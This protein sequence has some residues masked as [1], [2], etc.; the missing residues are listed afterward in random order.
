MLRVHSAGKLLG[1]G[2]GQDALESLCRDVGY[3]DVGWILGGVVI[4]LIIGGIV[5]DKLW[6]PILLPLTQ[7][8]PEFQRDA[9]ESY[10]RDQGFYSTTVVGVA[11]VGG[12]IIGLLGVRAW[13]TPR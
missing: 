12:F 13:N 6:T 7:I 9:M 5:G 1:Q 4:A 2:E 8:S 3:Y 10:C 11:V